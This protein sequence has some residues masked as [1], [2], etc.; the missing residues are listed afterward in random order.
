MECMPPTILPF[1]STYSQRCLNC[2]GAYLAE[3]DL[4]GS[5]VLGGDESVG[6]GALAGDVEIHNFSFVVLHVCLLLKVID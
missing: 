6:S 5:V 4:D 1:S 2:C 3:L